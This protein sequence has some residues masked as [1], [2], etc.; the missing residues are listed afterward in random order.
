MF[1]DSLLCWQLSLVISWFWFFPLQAGAAQLSAPHSSGSA[2]AAVGQGLE[3]ELISWAGIIQ[4]CFLLYH[5]S[6]LLLPGTKS[7][8]Q[9][10]GLWM[11]NHH[12]SLVSGLPWMRDRALSNQGSFTEA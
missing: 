1:A 8:Q 9:R 4:T 3:G 2:G 5:F 12:L 6:L 10:P 7:C 11:G